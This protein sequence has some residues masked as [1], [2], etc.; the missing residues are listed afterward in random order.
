MAQGLESFVVSLISEATLLRALNLYTQSVSVEADRTGRCGGFR[1]D[2]AKNSL[3]KQHVESKECGVILN[4]AI[5]ST[6]GVDMQVGCN[7]LLHLFSVVTQRL[8]HHTCVW[9]ST[10]GLNH[11]MPN[12]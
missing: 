12:S 9:C 8:T 5:Q 3:M 6:E 1:R 4:L 10:F 7:I 2:K 11:A